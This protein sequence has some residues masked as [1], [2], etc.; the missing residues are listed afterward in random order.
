MQWQR[1][2]E[3]VSFYCP[4]KVIVLPDG[5]T[6]SGYSFDISL[7]GVGI[8]LNTLLKP[9]QDVCISFQ[10]RGDSDKC[11]EESVWGR[12]ASLEADVDCNLVGIEFLGEVHRLRQLLLATMVGSL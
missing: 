12:V 11:V 3:R 4:V 9:G 2:Y 10:L 7:G 8:T 5:P 1:R 6:L